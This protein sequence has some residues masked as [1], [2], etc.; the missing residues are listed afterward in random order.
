MPSRVG[1]LNM[2]K[3]LSHCLIAML[4]ESSA[5]HLSADE[6]RPV[7]GEAAAALVAF[8]DW[9]LSFMS[10]HNIPGGSI[11][12]MR[13]GKL[14][15]ARGFGY[16]DRD[17]KL[18]VVP[19]S[20]FRIAS[21]SKPITAVA[22]L[23]L[24][25][26]GKLKLDNK[27]LEILKYEPHFEEGGTLDER[28]KEITI[29]HCLAH[30]GGWDRNKSYDPMFQARRMAASMKIDFPVLPEHV[31]R[32]QL[33]QP[34]DFSPGEHYAYSNFGYCLLGRVIEKLTG[35]SYEEYVLKEVF[36][37]LGITAP[38]MGKSLETEQVEGEVRYYDVNNEQ[39]IASTGP[40]AGKEKVPLSYGVWRQETL[41]AHG[42]WIASSIDLAKFAAAFDSL[43]D[44]NGQATT[45]GGLLQP[46]TVRD[47]FS[48]H[49]EMSKPDAEGKG[50]QDYG[51]GWML[52]P[53][54]HPAEGRP[55]RMVAR[56]G[57]ALPCTASTMIHFP[58]GT[59]VAVLF[60]LGRTPEG[61]FF[62]GEIDPAMMELVGKLVAPKE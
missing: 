27:I 37:P 20:L 39:E 10:K 15:Y 7:T 47:M 28:W 40:G 16:A 17:K 4:V 35:L 58:D 61:K 32:Y 5:L 25:E 6:P 48:P 51:Y 3:I 54:A 26:Q 52:R 13:D 36:L 34:L 12:M 62:G 44:A 22:I 19:E 55:P 1:H 59:N 42:G 60:N 30:T 14:V 53:E 57:G 2:H 43:S 31:I 46:M 11:A 38:R 49:A 41:D 29:A 23:K 18:A 8:D 9:M 33:G 50:G 21:I 24:V 56:H 45:R